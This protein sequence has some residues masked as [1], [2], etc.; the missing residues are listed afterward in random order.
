MRS[1]AP[2]VVRINAPALAA[3]ETAGSFALGAGDWVLPIRRGRRP[4]RPVRRARS[5]EERRATA[6]RRQIL[7]PPSTGG[8]VDLYFVEDGKE[9]AYDVRSTA[10]GSDT[11]KFEVVSQVAGQPVT[12]SMPDLSTLPADK[13]VTLVDTA[14]NR[15]IYLRTTQSLHVRVP[16]P[17]RARLRDR[18]RPAQHRAL[19]ITSASANVSNG[20][21]VALTYALSQDAAV[22]VEI[23]NISGRPIVGHRRESRECGRQYRA[24]GPPQQRT[25]VPA[26]ATW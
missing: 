10:T 3:A 8:S 14:A 15:R 2:R 26:D 18:C 21:Q 4:R 25:S 23:M 22:T 5:R 16:R 13:Q 11:W 20:G 19:T 17:A 1:D 6:R 9:L 12:I 24:V 7:N